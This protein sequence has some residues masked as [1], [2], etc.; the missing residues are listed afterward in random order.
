MA[1]L[2]G[3]RDGGGVGYFL[4]PDDWWQ[5]GGNAAIGLA[6]VAGL[7]DGVRLHRPRRAG[8]WW[9]L[10]GGLLCIVAGDFVYALY[11]RVLHGPAP[12]PSLA[13]ALSLARLPADRP[14]PGAAGARANDRPGPGQLDRRHLRGQWVRPALVDLPD[15][16]DS[17]QQRA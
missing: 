10:A 15:G 14:Q 7:V 8:L 12:F 11:E 3:G 5:T 1:G 2:P 16:T 17:H 6:G 9:M 13:D 4:L